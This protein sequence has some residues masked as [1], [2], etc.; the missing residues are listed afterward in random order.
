MQAPVWSWLTVRRHR[1]PSI[2]A[3]RREHPPQPVFPCNRAAMMRVAALFVLSL[4]L[5]GAKVHATDY[6][7]VGAE[8]AIL[9]NAPTERARKVFI[10]PRGMP[11]ELILNLDG[12]SKIRDAEGDLSWVASRMLVNKRTVV[13]TSVR[14]S[15]LAEHVDAAP[16]VATADKGVLFDMLTPAASGWIKVMHE[17]GTSGYVR[18]AEVWGD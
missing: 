1:P 2:D 9:Y 17:D 12:W 5:C 10:A 7:S 16:V 18:T 15:I 3:T 6:K 4:S 13:V 11:V 14:A 8:P